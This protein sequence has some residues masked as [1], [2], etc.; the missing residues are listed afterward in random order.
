MKLYI[1]LIVFLILNTGCRHSSNAVGPE[2][3]SV[4]CING[5]AVS[6]VQGSLLYTFAIAKAT[7]QAHDTLNG[8]LTI[9]NQSSST[10]TI[11]LPVYVP[12]SLKDTSGRTVMYGPQ[13]IA[14]YHTLVPLG[15]HQSQTFLVMHE[16]FVDTSGLLLS[17]GSYQLQGRLP[18]S[19]SFAL[20]IILQ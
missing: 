5:V 8:T 15:P 10:D 2:T 18:T 3:D 16:A 13:A 11:G 19:L 14:N 12:W 6:D 20:S 7:F 1:A 4:P 9:A 17:A